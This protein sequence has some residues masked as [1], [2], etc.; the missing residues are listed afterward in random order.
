[1]KGEEPMAQTTIRKGT[2][3]TFR[4]GL[5]WSHGKVV[6]LD[7]DTGYAKIEYKGKNGAT[8]TVSRKIGNLK[9]AA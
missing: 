1:M 7:S 5:G 2:K 6:E 3:V 8:G 4:W 9:R